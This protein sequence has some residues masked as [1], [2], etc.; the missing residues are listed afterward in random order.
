MTY[1]TVLLSLS[2]VFIAIIHVIE[3]KPLHPVYSADCSH[4]YCYFS[5][6]NLSK[7]TYF[8]VRSNIPAADVIFVSLGGGQDGS[9][10]HTLTYQICEAFPNVE[11]IAASSLG[12]SRIQPNAF[13][14]CKNLQRLDLSGNS[15]KELELGHFRSF[16]KL[17]EISV[18]NNQL[19]EV[20]EV[21]LVRK[22]TRLQSVR[23]C[24]N[25]KMKTDRLLQIARYFKANRI[26]FYELDYC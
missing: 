16:D 8:E 4:G 15:L 20:D 12:L 25:D 1:S 23:L 18:S 26:K 14:G 24:P 21:E 19:T 5:N 3:S 7:V 6:L 11:E 2:I 10:M 17:K 22:F 13:A 9:K